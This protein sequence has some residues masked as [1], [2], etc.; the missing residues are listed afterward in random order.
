MV[1]NDPSPAPPARLSCHPHPN[2]SVTQVAYADGLR[3]LSGVLWEMRVIID[4]GLHWDNQVRG[5]PSP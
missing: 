1:V 3:V 2:R 5:S 4:M